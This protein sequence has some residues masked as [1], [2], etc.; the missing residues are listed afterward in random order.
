MYNICSRFQNPAPSQAIATTISRQQKGGNF[1]NGHLRVDSPVEEYL[2]SGPVVKSDLALMGSR[3]WPG[4]CHI[5]AALKSIIGFLSC[6][7]VLD[8]RASTCEP[9][10]IFA[11]A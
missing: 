4:L 3:V 11:L 8:A 6:L 5:C 1:S 2:V 9:L 7:F 10:V